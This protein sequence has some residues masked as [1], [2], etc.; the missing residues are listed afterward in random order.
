M[1]AA[2]FHVA[3]VFVEGKHP[4]Q[5]CEDVV[6]VTEHLVAVVDGATDETGA[7][8]AG[9]TGGRFAADVVAGALEAEPAPVDARAFADRLAHA[10]AGAVE[11]EVGTLAADARRP[12]ASVACL[13]VATRQVWRIGDCNVRIGDACHPGS[14]RVDDAAYGFRAAINAALLADGTPLEEVLADDPGA[15]AAR[16]LYDVQQHLAN[17]TGPWG[18]GCIDGRPVADEHIEVFD[19]P[20]GPCRVVLGSDGYPVLHPTLAATEEHLAALMAVDPAGIDELWSM[21]KGLRPGSR[22]M[23]DRAYVS[24]DLDR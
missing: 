21:G 20:A 5:V 16:S 14:K 8:F 10:L 13:V 19:V 2:P 7:R 9:T 24:V 23:D 18:Y 6:V 3:E 1:T 17:T 22:A 11:A 4:D 12:L 15:E